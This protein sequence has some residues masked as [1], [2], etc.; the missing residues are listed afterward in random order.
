MS[1]IPRRRWVP[2]VVIPV[3]VI[4][5]GLAVFLGRDAAPESMV[6]ATLSPTTGAGDRTGAAGA[7]SS[8]TAT[9]PATST[10]PYTIK[11][12]PT[13]VATDSPPTAAGPD[14][15]L[16]YAGYEPSTGTVRANGFVAGVI[17]DGASC[18]LTLTSGNREISTSSEAVAD[19]T[20]TSC[21][22]METEDGVPSGTWEATLSYSGTRS[23][24]IEVRVP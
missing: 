16:T 1:P 24:S 18:T 17:E 20:T 9:S 13:L 12:E 23:S 11:P 19:A 3:L 14:V 8:G 2:A 4:A 22:L 15:V 10:A 7:A 6:A 21:G 5:A